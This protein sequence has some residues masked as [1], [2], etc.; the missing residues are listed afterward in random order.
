MSNLKDGIIYKTRNQISFPFLM[1]AS[2]SCMLEISGDKWSCYVEFFLKASSWILI[3]NLSLMII[4]LSCNCIIISQ[5][6][7]RSRSP[8]HFIFKFHCIPPALPFLFCFYNMALAIYS[9]PLITRFKQLT[10]QEKKFVMHNCIYNQNAFL[11]TT[12]KHLS[13]PLIFTLPA[14]MTLLCL[15]NY[16]VIILHSRCR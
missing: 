3:N 6:L 12:V 11:S 1:S 7:L 10:L 8:V 5:H 14:P 2:M 15:M 13:F 16:R 4:I 9:F